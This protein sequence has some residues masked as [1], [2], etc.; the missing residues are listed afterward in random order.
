MTILTYHITIAERIKEHRKANK[1]S[2]SEFGKLIGVSPQAVCKWEQNICYPDICF[3]PHLARILVC[4][5]DD[6]FEEYEGNTN[7]L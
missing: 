1:L 7:E 5:I 6:F 2:Q 4:T 3:L